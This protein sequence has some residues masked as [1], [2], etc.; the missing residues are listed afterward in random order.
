M[1]NSLSRLAVL[2]PAFKPEESLID[3]SD[4]LL[5]KGFH[6]FVIVDDGSGDDYLPIFRRLDDMG[7]CVLTH[8]VNMGKGRALKT[9]M[10]HIILNNPGIDGIITADADGQHLVKDIVRVGETLLEHKNTLVI[11]SRTFSGDI[12]LRSR[13]GNS[14]TRKVF[15]FVSGHKVYDTQSGLRGLPSAALKDL[16]SLS[17][18]R[19]EYEMNVLLEAASLRLDIKEIDIETVYI[20]G[21]SRSHFNPLTDSFRIYRL[22]ILFAGSS[23]FAF[24]VDFLMFALITI[25]FPGVLLA[26]VI[27][28]RVVSSLVNFLVNRK[29]VFSKKNPD[30]TL[31]KHLFGYYL[32][33][34]L[35]M[36][37]NYGLISLFTSLGI[38]VYLSKVMT[39]V[40]LFFVSFTIQKRVIF[41]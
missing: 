32:L 3:L 36:A 8:A 4:A 2:I 39:E 16:L 27:G 1:E 23:L 24:F 20:D 31:Q 29:L 21:N 18:E 7:C 30:G 9:G 12:P 34:V 17:G 26:A 28:A 14:I 40:L 15:S 13:F 11:G 41:K 22:I 25:I 33:V 37:S 10:N 19:Y 6:Q 35:I 38:N 5:K